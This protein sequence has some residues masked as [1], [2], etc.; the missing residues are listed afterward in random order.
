MALKHKMRYFE[1]SAL[2]N[3]NVTE[4]FNFMFEMTFQK[5]LEAG[6]FECLTDRSFTTTT[7]DGSSVYGDRTPK[8]GKR[9]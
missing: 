3:T 6:E 5:K 8:V 1:T 2:N 7:E 4:M 9:G